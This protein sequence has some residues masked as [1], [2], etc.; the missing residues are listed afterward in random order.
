[1]TTTPDAAAVRRDP[2][3]RAPLDDLEP[4]LLGR[5]HDRPHGEHRVRVAGRLLE[6]RERDA[7]D[8]QR[9]PPLG[10]LLGREDLGAD[11]ERLLHRHHVADRLLLLRRRDHHVAMPDEARGAAEL[12]LG[13]CEHPGG[14]DGEPDRDL[15]RVVLADV[16]SGVLRRAAADRRPLDERH[17]AVAELRQEVGDARAHDPAPDHDRV[18]AP[19]HRA[20]RSAVV[21]ASARSER[22]ISDVSGAPL[23]CRGG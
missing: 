18:G 6:T 5:A 9:R 22:T 23:S 17:L 20:A 21:V 14:A 7:V 1:L 16:R 4:P 8:V 3:D 11:A 10:H 19:D 12:L 15:V 2:D 13:A